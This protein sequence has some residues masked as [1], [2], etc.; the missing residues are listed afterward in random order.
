MVATSQVVSD[1]GV[2]TIDHPLARLERPLTEEDFWALPDDEN[3]YE[4]IGGE[5]FVTPPPVLEHESISM[6]LSF[7]LYQTLRVPELAW[8]LS[9][10]FGVRL[11]PSD[12]V[13]PDLAVVRMARLAELKG[14]LLEVVPDLV[15]E[16]ASPSTRRR[17]RVKKRVQ[18]QEAGIPEYWLVDP[19]KRTVELLALE[20]GQYREVENEGGIATSRVFPQVAIDVAHLFSGKPYVAATTPSTTG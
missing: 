14:K 20:G 1:E 16:I 8:V 7:A 9:A 12:I 13:Q 5:L 2:V 18:Y 17:D 4:I 10:P 11:G 3:R 6:Y 15:I 19:M